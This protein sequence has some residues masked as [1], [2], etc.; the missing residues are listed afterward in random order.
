MRSVEP[1]FTVNDVERS[2]RFYT[3]VLGFIVGERWSDGGVLRGVTLA[4]ALRR[5]LSRT[6]WAKGRDRKKGEAVNIWCSTAQDVDALAARIKAGGGRLTAEPKP[7]LGC[8]QP[9]GGRSGRVPPDDLPGA[10]TA[11][12]LGVA[13]SG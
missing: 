11:R 13:T 1:T 9:L 3:E 8:A 2:V 10:V 4:A 6:D 12:L 5:D 7:I